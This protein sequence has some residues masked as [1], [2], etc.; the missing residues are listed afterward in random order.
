MKTNACVI[1]SAWFTVLCSAALGDNPAGYRTVQP[2]VGDPFLVRDGFATLEPVLAG[3]DGKPLPGWV[4]AGHMILLRDGRLLLAYASAHRC[5]TTTSN[6]GG[7]TWTEPIVADV[8]LPGEFKDAKTH[9]PAIVE[10]ADGHLWLFFYGLIKYD[11]PNPDKSINPLWATKSIDGG[12]SWSA[13]SMICDGYVGMLQGA[14][15]TSKGNIVVPVCRYAAVHRFVG[16]CVVSTDGGETWKRTKELDVPDPEMSPKYPF[17][18]SSKISRGAIEPSVAELPDGRLLMMIRTIHDSMFQS[19]SSDG[20][21]TW[22]DPQR[23]SISCG[24]PGNVAR[25]PSGRIAI[26]YNPAN[27]ESDFGKR[28]GSPIGYDRQSIAI[29]NE[30]GR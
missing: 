3:S 4:G 27:Y 7:A 14:I 19:Y 16:L 17:P 22:S 1:L 18:L 12:Q 9:R 20:G 5:R 6:D 10:S 13:P 29:L 15:V 8:T 25:L 28:R 23:S 2:L 21:L 26:A 11:V 30:D 24:G